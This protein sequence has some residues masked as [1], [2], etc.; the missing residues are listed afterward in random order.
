LLIWTNPKI[1][2]WEF[3]NFQCKSLSYCVLH[4]SPLLFRFVKATLHIAMNPNSGSPFINV[5]VT[6]LCFDIWCGMFGWWETIPADPELLWRRLVRWRL[7]L[8]R[9]GFVSSY[10]WS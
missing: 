5:H 4:P 10:P 3:I 9:Q 2:K 7:W 1:I 6:P 8:H